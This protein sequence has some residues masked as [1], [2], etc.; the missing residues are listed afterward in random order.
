MAS[1]DDIVGNAVDFSYGVVP[2]RS[3]STVEGRIASIEFQE[4]RASTSWIGIANIEFEGQSQ[5]N[6]FTGERTG[7]GGSWVQVVSWEWSW[8]SSLWEEGL[9]C[10][11]S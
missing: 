3:T 11:D 10:I 9:D 5:R 6:D 2:E 4:G 8:S 7:T 1:S